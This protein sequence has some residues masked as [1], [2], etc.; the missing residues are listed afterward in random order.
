MA[1][2]LKV[3]LLQEKVHS[4]EFTPGGAKEEA[5]KAVFFVFVFVFIL[6]WFLYP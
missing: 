5:Q 2:G 3:A 4:K 1:Q 6:V